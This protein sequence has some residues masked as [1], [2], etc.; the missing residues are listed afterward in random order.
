MSWS[1]L[2]TTIPAV[3]KPLLF[4]IKESKSIPLSEI[5]N[6]KDNTFLNTKKLSD[7]LKF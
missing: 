2:I 4:S 1:L 3:P 7:L 6:M 5:V